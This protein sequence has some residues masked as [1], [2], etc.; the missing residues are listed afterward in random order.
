M[1]S[2]RVKRSYGSCKMNV[3][4]SFRKSIANV[5][6]DIYASIKGEYVYL[7]KTDRV[8]LPLVMMLVMMGNKCAWFQSNMPR[9]L[10]DSD[11]KLVPKTLALISKY[12]RG[13]LMS[14]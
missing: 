1:T 6:I 2:F 7:K 11:E 5:N 9:D 14:K 13:T 8:I 10:E 12:K 4:F 3:I